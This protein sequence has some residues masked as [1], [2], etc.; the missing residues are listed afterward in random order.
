MQ[1]HC[2]KEKEYMKA[3]D[4]L[5]SRCSKLLYHSSIKH[6]TFI[7]PETGQDTTKKTG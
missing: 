5:K 4:N 1:K 2:A 7:G 3:T 6:A